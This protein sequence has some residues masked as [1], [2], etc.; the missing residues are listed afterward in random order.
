MLVFLAVLLSTLAAAQQAPDVNAP[1]TI[2]QSPALVNQRVAP[3]TSPTVQPIASHFTQCRVV[4]PGG[5][6]ADRG[7]SQTCD[8][9]QERAAK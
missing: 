8:L 5:G 2:H 7:G 9:H 1:Q 3:I 4:H 6:N